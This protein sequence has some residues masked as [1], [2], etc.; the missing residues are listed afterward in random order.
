MHA[1]SVVFSVILVLTL[2]L[3]GIRASTRAPA[4]TGQLHLTFTESSPLSSVDTILRRLDMAEHPPE[5]MEA[6]A[7]ELS[8][9]VYVPPDYRPNM[10][11]GLLVWMGMSDVPSAWLGVLARHRLI[12]VCTNNLKG[13][14]ARYGAALD[15]VHNLKK[16]YNIDEERVYA[17]GFS[18]GGQLATH[19]V[20]C[21]PEVFR[22]GLFLL[23]GYFYL[24][25]QNENGWRDP[26]VEA[27]YPFWKGRLD[28]LKKT[29]RLVIMRGGRDPQWTPQEGRADFQALCLDGFTHV[30]YFEVPGLRHT[31]PNTVWF[32][33]CVAALDQSRPMTLPITSPTTKPNPLPGQISQAQR[34]LASAQYYLDLKPL[35]MP[36]AIERKALKDELEEMR[37]APQEK[38]RKYL[39]QVLDEYPTTPAAA[40]A[41]SLL[42][43]LKQ[44]AR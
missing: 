17:S 12:L 22:G 30:T 20:R 33:K 35:R 21:F 13:R 19:M 18:A 28:E 40:R 14:P 7:Y 9:D 15:A 4:A 36:K 27:A 32:A 11:Y 34:I 37:D 29:T 10:P 8:F 25:R 6:M 26:T 3:S 5:N 1:R 43:K 39:Q 41:R 31:L 44:E 42:S 38:A 16:L 24:S 23:G 2:G